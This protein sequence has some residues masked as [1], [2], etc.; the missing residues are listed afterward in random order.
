MLSTKVASK[1]QHHQVIYRVT[2]YRRRQRQD[3]RTRDSNISPSTNIVMHAAEERNGMTNAPSLFSIYSNHSSSHRSYGLV[4]SIIVDLPSTSFTCT[5]DR[6]EIETNGNIQR[7]ALS[8]GSCEESC[9]VCTRRHRAS[10]AVAH[11]S[12]EKKPKYCTPSSSC[13]ARSTASASSAHE[14]RCLCSFLRLSHSLNPP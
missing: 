10:V 6:E 8:R 14:C 3:V 9:I 7:N 5:A 12:T 1:Q 13:L 4:E 2:A 11:T